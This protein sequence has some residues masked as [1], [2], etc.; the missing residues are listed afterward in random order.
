MKTAKKKKWWF[1]QKL[2]ED[3]VEDAISSI[4]MQPP[5]RK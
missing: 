2:V 1:L 3:V 5:F 4:K